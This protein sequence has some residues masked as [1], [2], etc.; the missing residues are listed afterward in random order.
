[1]VWALFC[2]RRVSPEK[3]DFCAPPRDRHIGGAAEYLSVSGWESPFDPQARRI[4]RDRSNIEVAAMYILRSIPIARSIRPSYRTSARD[5]YQRYRYDASYRY[6][7][8][9]SSRIGRPWLG[10]CSFTG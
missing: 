5:H 9:Q 3:F 10:L 8:Y 1:M 2:W 4:I 7:G 6:A